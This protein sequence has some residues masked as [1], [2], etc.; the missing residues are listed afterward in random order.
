MTSKIIQWKFLVALVAVPVLSPLGVL[1]PLAAQNLS[2]IAANDNRTVAGDQNGGVRKLQLEIRKGVWHPESD[3]GEAMA[4]YA[5]GEVGK[6]LQIPGPAIRVPQGTTL[7]ISLHSALG[8]PATVHGLHQRPG[9][10][11]DV[12]TLAAGET[13]HIRFVA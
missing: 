1:S 10:D 4:V 11:A 6:T 2:P 12:I 9:K 7:D 13:Q 3:S 8:V 5:F